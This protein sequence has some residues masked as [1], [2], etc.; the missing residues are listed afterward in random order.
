M[1]DH[2]SDSLDLRADASVERGGLRVETED[3]GVEDGP[4]QWRRAIEEALGSCAP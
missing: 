4:E 2:V 3:G 1:K